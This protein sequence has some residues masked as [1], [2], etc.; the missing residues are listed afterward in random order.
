MLSLKS[1][2][3]SRQLLV[4]CPT[5]QAVWQQERLHGHQNLMGACKALEELVK[6]AAAPLER[7]FLW[8]VFLKA[9]VPITIIS[10]GKEEYF[11]IIKRMCLSCM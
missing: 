5:R 10:I 1:I 3:S 2:L 9:V 11:A 8:P 4:I 7:S 6:P